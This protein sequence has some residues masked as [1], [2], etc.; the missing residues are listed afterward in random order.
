MNLGS[1][2]TGALLLGGLFAYDI[3]M[4]FGTGRAL[5]PTRVSIMEEVA[6]RLDGPIKLFFPAGA[7]ALG[8]RAHALLG[9]GDI[10]VP[11]TFLALLLRFDAARAGG[12]AGAADFPARY[13]NAGMAAYVAGL[14]ATTLAMNWSDTAQP[15]L[16][17][18]VPAVLG[19]TAALAAARGE[20][21]ALWAY[22]EDTP[23]AVVADGKKAD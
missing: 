17:Y 21:A 22:A 6:V 19:A 16:L 14:A 20:V 8:G 23:A 1:V 13:F 11:G 7:A 10:I 9:L 5:G 18:L 2:Q 15:A 4:V 12:G 3:V